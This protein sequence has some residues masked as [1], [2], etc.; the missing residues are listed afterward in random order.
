MR[1]LSSASASLPIE[2]SGPGVPM[3]RDCAARMFVR[4]STSDSIQSRVKRSRC[5][6]SWWSDGRATPDTARLISPLPRGGTDAADRDA[7]V[8][9]RGE[10]HVPAVARRRRGVRRRGCA[11][12]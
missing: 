2:P 3:R 10:R 4:R 9:E 7:L 12:R 11:R 1:L 6:G 5:A 8:H